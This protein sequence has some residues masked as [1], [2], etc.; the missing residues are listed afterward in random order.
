VTDVHD[1]AGVQ[2]A[3]GVHATAGVRTLTLGGLPLLV[4]DLPDGPSG[5]AV[6]EALRTAGLR[7]LAGVVGV[8]FPRGAGVG[9]L[10]DG[11]AVRLVDERERALLRLVRQGLSADWVAAALRLRG[12]MLVVATG[13]GVERL[14]EPATLGARLEEEARGGRVDGAIV[15]VSDRRPRL[16]LVF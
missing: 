5:G 7:P 10:L 13:V 3:S 2:D 14:D 15:G 6:R 4:V 9:L 11:D 1:P 8:E 16:P 12:T